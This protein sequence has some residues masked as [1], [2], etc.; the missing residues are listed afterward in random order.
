MNCYDI[1]QNNCYMTS[2]KNGYL[3]NWAKHD[4][5]Q[6]TKVD[7]GIHRVFSHLLYT[8]NSSIPNSQFQNVFMIPTN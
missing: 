1:I 3:H 2:Q 5:E 4:T 7:R 6:G 8:V